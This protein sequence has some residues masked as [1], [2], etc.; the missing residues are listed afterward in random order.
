MSNITL[1]ART[2]V[3]LYVA[4]GISVGTQLKVTNL[5]TGDVR[6]SVSEAGLVDNHIPLNAYKQ[7]LNEATDAGA[8]AL[9]TGGGGINVEGVI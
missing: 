4:S 7:A 8:W 2:A 6:L 3:D 1:P 9:S 5:T